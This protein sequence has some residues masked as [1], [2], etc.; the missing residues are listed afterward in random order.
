MFA[1]QEVIS[2]ADD[3]GDP[4]GLAEILWQHPC[5]PLRICFERG[6]AASLA[7]HA[8]AGLKAAIPSET[9]GLLFGSAERHGPALSIR[10]SAA[11]FVKGKAQYFN[12]DPSDRAALMRTLAADRAAAAEPVGYFRSDT[13]DQFLLTPEDQEFVIKNIPKSNSVALIIRPFRMGACMVGV[14]FWEDDR[15]QSEFTDFEMPLFASESKSSTNPAIP[16]PDASP[17]SV[18][19]VEKAL[20]HLNSVSEG[21]H[22]SDEPTR[23]REQATLRTEPATPTEVQRAKPTTAVLGLLVGLTLCLSALLV[24]VLLISYQRFGF[25]AQ[26]QTAAAVTA[27]ALDAAKKRDA[28]Q[29]G[30]EL[31][32]SRPAPNQLNLTWNRLLPPELQRGE[33][34]IVDGGNRRVLKLDRAQLLLG[35]LT[36][37]SSDSDISFRLDVLSAK[38]TLLSEYIRVVGTAAPRIMRSERLQPTP[39]QASAAFMT[40]GDARKPRA[41]P[42]AASLPDIPAPLLGMPPALLAAPPAR[43]VFPAAHGDGEP[44]V[45]TPPPNAS[46]R[47][48]GAL[49]FITAAPDIPQQPSVKTERVRAPLITPAR[50]LQQIMPKTRSIFPN[51]VPTPRRLAV[52]VVVGLNGK[53]KAVTTPEWPGLLAAACVAAAWQWRFEPALR[54]GHPVVSDYRIVFVFNVNK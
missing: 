17:F 13:R 2:A 28:P 24:G 39:Q 10:V 30:L 12:I 34:D 11:A 41:E 18:P 3:S 23:M 38:E 20:A 16:T 1:D 9:G 46:D 7:Q 25:A 44:N 42:V 32:V 35:K 36:Y 21:T 50:P 22:M 8:L 26:Q 52:D 33:L 14:F 27:P 48:Q 6:V 47:L 54:N 51:G 31:E 4:E 29:S 5:R 45:G 19:S 15:L 49:S 37:F 53:V 43:D 40:A